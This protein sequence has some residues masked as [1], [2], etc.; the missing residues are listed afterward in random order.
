[1]TREAKTRR[2]HARHPAT[3][4]P[5]CGTSLTWSIPLGCYV[6]DDNS[7]L[8]PDGGEHITPPRRRGDTNGPSR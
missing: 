8:C 4:C 6:G 7:G 3:T 5:S 2:A 1:M